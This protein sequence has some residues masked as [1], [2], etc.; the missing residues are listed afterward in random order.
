MKKLFYLSFALTLA[1]CGPSSRE[2][3]EKLNAQ[4]E[5]ARYRP[6]PA[7]LDA[8]LF[9]GPD[10]KLWMLD[11]DSLPD[12]MKESDSYLSFKL[13]KA[14]NWVYLHYDYQN[15]NQMVQYYISRDTLVFDFGGY[16]PSL[17]KYLVTTVNDSMMTLTD[18]QKNQAGIR[19][20]K[21]KQNP[22]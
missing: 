20:L 11:S 10:E 19:Y 6:A 5:S 2:V 8:Q 13:K 22:Y 1:A 14:D 9:T 7:I 21:T 16:P 12:G 17:M 3:Q 18:L 4:L 15:S